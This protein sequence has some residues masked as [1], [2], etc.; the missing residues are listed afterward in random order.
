MRTLKAAPR[1]QRQSIRVSVPWLGAEAQAASSSTTA[2]AL[3]FMASPKGL[4]FARA[5]AGGPSALHSLARERCGDIA[6]RIDGDQSAIAAK[7]FHVLECVRRG[8]FKRDA[9]I[10]DAGGHV[11]GD[12][13]AHEIL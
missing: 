10:G 13:G 8:F 1:S 12:V 4:H 5:G 2:R 11:G 7:L 9:G 3:C 6:F